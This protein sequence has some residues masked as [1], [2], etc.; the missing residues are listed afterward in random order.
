IC[1]AL[2]FGALRTTAEGQSVFKLIGEDGMGLLGES[3]KSTE[4]MDNH[5]FFRLISCTLALG[6]NGCVSL[7]DESSAQSFELRENHSVRID[8]IL[9]EVVRSGGLVFDSA[10]VLY[11]SNYLH[12]GTIG[13]YTADDTSPPTTFIDLNEW[14]TSYDDRSPDI[15]GLVLD[16]EGRLIGADAGTGKIIRMAH[17][18]SKVEVLADSYEG[19][20]FDS[21]HDV[22]LSPDGV[23]FA[24]SPGD[25]VIY[26]IRPEEGEVKILNYDLV[27]GDGLAISPDG[28]RLVVT[29]PDAA[30]VLIFALDKET[31]G[32]FPSATIDF[33]D[34][35]QSPRGLAFDPA[36]R[37]YVAMGESGLVNV[38]DPSD[39]K[40]LRTYEVGDSADR[41][42][43]N[44]GELWVSGD[45]SEGLRRVK[46]KK[47]T[48]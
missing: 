20:L 26:C 19:M 11:F 46:L 1:N 38:F 41:L 10:G 16:R 43:I 25:G 32:I 30:R 17:D 3:F 12:R 33:S 18:A 37:L 40:L 42:F 6:G 2:A 44:N 15:R 31:S 29:E 48:P 47:A 35:G 24:S 13:R 23:I 36:G 22:A 9:P 34:S 4:C 7:H 39:T 27:R 14:M 21:V 28:A 8:P 45:Q 5:L